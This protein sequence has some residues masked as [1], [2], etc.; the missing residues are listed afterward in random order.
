MPLAAEDVYPVEA[1]ATWAVV[2]VS[3]GKGQQLVGSPPFAEIL[4][5]D[6][7]AKLDE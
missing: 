4:V 2:F 1:I 3:L 7:R 6:E 5:L